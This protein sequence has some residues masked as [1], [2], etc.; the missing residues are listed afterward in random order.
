MSK[1]GLWRL[2]GNGAFAEFFVADAR[3]A[4]HIPDKLASKAA[5]PLLCAGVT[6]YKGLKETEARPGQWVAIIGV[7]AWDIWRSSMRRPWVFRWSASTW[8]MKNSHSLAHWVQP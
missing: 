5:A 6:T 4:A 3:Y 7:E 8:T 1:G 2:Y